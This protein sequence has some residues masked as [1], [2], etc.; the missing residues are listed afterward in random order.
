[1]DSFLNPA[2]AAETAPSTYLDTARTQELWTAIKTALAGK[3]DT[4]TLEGYTTPD[5]VATAITLA[6]TDYAKTT[7][8]QTAIA[9]ALVNYMTSAETNAAIANAIA[10]AAHITVQ[11]VDSLPETGTA[12]VIYFVPNSGSS[13]NTKDEYMW[14]NGAWELF[15]TTEINLSGYWSKENLRAMTAQE[16]QSILTA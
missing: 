8:V 3:A 4:S 14:I 5:A 16:L 2:R 1:M 10:A 11:T 12:N 15:G 6:L 9:T 7:A 13:T